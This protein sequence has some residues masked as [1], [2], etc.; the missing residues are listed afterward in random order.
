MQNAKEID[1]LCRMIEESVGRRIATPMDFSFLSSAIAE[2]CHEK[3]GI[4]TLKRVWGYVDRYES[5]RHS[6]LSILSHFVGFHDWEDFLLKY[7]DS[8]S[9]VRVV[10]GR[11]LNALQLAENAMLRIAWAPDCRC[12]L[13]HRSNGN[14][15]VVSSNVSAIAVGDTF[16]CSNLII[17][18]PLYLDTFIHLD[19][20][21]IM[22]VVGN[23][24]G[25]TAID[26]L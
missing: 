16:H 25:L 21:S 13:R 20:E 14:F 19:N 1:A 6:T 3:L 12:V 24:G 9:A 18:E 4:T 26:T 15:K 23:L 11:I 22:L 10:R 5:F 17:G 7:Q 2:R 8:S